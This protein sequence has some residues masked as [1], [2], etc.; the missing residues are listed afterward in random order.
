MAERQAERDE[1]AVVLAVD[2]ERERISLGV[3]QLDKDPFAGFLSEHPKNSMV[4]EPP[5]S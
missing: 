2:P 5:P 4:T 3:K 1:Q